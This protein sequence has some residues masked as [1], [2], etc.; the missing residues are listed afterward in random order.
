[1]TLNGILQIFFY[2]VLLTLLAKPVGIYL[3][4]VYNGEKTFLD[5][6]FR[7]IERVIY[8]IT[9]VEAEKEMNWKQYGIAMLVFS[10]VSTIALYAIQRLQFFLPSNPQGF[11]GL[12]EH[13]SFNTAV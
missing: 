13:L 8:A 4:K 2:L 1:M 5:F 6:L 11:A 12:S 7:P 3:L 9:R 10:L